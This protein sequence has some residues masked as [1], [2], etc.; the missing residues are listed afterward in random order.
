MT[1]ELVY[2][3]NVVKENNY[4]MKCKLCLKNTADQTGSHILSCMSVKS[5]IGNRGE[6]K[7]FVISTDPF[8]NYLKNTKGE[9]I[10]EDYILCRPCEQRL[11]YVESYIAEELFNKVKKSNF[12]SNFPRKT[13]YNIEVIECLRINPFAFHIFLYSQIWRA[14]ISNTQIFCK[15]N[16]ENEI[17]EF[18]RI[19]IN[20]TLPERNDYRGVVLKP[21]IWFKQLES[22]KN[23]LEKIK[24]LIAT[25][26]V[27]ED[28]TGDFI[29]FHPTFKQPYSLMM[30]EWIIYFNV[31]E[32]FNEDI[33]D[34]LKGI[35]I[36]EIYN[37]G[38][39]TIR[40]IQID[41]SKWLQTRNNLRDIVKDQKL[42]SLRN[43][44]ASSFFNANGYIPDNSIVDKL[45]LQHLE[46]LERDI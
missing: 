13:V 2:K 20:N 21:K 16:L 24:Y 37:S 35:N 27:I 34:L 6:E 10:K 19:T 14:S 12:L 1:K 7:S 29:M 33:F 15:F 23:D 39:E 40:I 8:E 3:E 25:T 18:L 22:Y 32:S 45:V 43:E 38:K 46:S 41:K 28:T 9:E 36:P 30:N 17:E 44:I 11:A 42:K 31:N 26:D 4:E 5:M